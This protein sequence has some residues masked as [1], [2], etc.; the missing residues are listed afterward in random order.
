LEPDCD[1]RQLC[2]M[3][4][5][6]RS[7]AGSVGGADRRRPLERDESRGTGRS[8]LGGA[9]HIGEAREK[10]GGAEPEDEKQA[11]NEVAHGLEEFFSFSR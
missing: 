10:Y 5:K 3:S 6:V 9:R 11:R 7:R 1:L 4:R 8:G 2:Q